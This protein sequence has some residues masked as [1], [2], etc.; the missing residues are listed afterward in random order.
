M[1]RRVVRKLEVRRF[2]PVEERLWPTLVALA[3]L[4]GMAMGTAVAYLRPDDARWYAN[5]WT[6]VVA[7][8]LGS[9]LATFWLVVVDRGRRRR[10][11]QLAVVL[12]ILVHL[13]LLIACLEST[14]VV[15]WVRQQVA[16]RQ[17]TVRPK[18]APAIP[19]TFQ[20][21]VTPVPAER[22]WE[23]PVAVEPETKVQPQKIVR[24][25]Q[26]RPETPVQRQPRP[27]PQPT[28]TVKPERVVRDQT[29][30]SPQ[31]QASRTP[32]H[33]EARRTLSGASQPKVA[34]ASR[35]RPAVQA[36]A[37]SAG[38]ASAARSTQPDRTV[39]SNERADVRP[40]V[41]RAQSRVEAPE[42]ESRPVAR[43]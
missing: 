11:V 5:S 42:V 20:P 4:T 28:P 41:A 27:V 35:S 14:M 32:I 33:R 38:R 37:A 6:W 8:P 23:R 34:Q 15:A 16:Q 7:I 26:E 31:A 17:P 39:A 10:P 9:L 1:S 43:R 3:I 21:K 24:R 30:P 25:T 40:S 22:E 12:G 18:Q 29:R 2:R 19:K 13:V 36:R